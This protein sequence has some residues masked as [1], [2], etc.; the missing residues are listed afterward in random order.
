[1]DEELLR[2]RD[3]ISRVTIERERREMEAARAGADMIHYKEDLARI[4]GMVRTGNHTHTRTHSRAH[5]RTH[6]H[7]HARTHAHTHTDTH[8]HTHTHK[9]KKEK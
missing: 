2:M 5:A 7:T 8:S 6:A 1:M 4:T 9:K 3:E